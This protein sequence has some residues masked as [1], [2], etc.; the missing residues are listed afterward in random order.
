MKV[1]LSHSSMDREIAIA[2]RLLIEDCRDDVFVFCSSDDGAI[3]VGKDFTDV[4]YRHLDESDVFIPLLSVNYY[5]S[6]YCMIELGTAVGYLYQR[7]GIDG[8]DFIYPFCVYPVKPGNAVLGTPISNRHVA[9][10]RDNRQVHDF[11][12]NGIKTRNSI[13][14]KVEDFIHKVN[15]IIIQKD[16]M[17]EY[18]STVRSYA[19][20]DKVFYKDWKDFS[21]ASTAL[22]C[23]T[24]TTTFNLNPYERKKFIKPDFISTVVH[25]VDGIDLFKYLY[26]RPNAEFKFTVNNFTNSLKAISVELKYG[27]G[28][29]TT[30]LFD[31]VRFELVKGKNE[32]SFALDKFKCNKLEEISEICFVID[33]SSFSEDEGSFIIENMRIE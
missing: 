18:A 10:L 3:P 17:L 8:R 25:Y 5:K 24:I 16:S 2:L 11:I 7:Y 20:G 33:K 6:K 12:R 4:I 30:T 23:N 31:P 26:I 1:F 22:D 9:D 27:Y 28:N 15:S 19:A 29:S 13:N 14:R 21:N 32:C